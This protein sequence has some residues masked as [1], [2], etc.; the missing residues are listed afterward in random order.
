MPRIKVDV[1]E[2]PIFQTIIPVRI[3]DLNYGN[4]LGNDSLLSIIH[5]ARVQFLYSLGYS[6][7]NF[8]GV[9][10]IMADVAIEYKSQGYY[11]DQLKVSIGVKDISRVGFDITYSITKSENGREIIVAK[12]KTG[13]VTF[14]YSLNKVIELPATFLE[15]LP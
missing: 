4:H 8:A 3:T 6:E 10:L 9:G 5:E 12:A 14:D 1:A 13:M 2:N 15:K 7:Q 11:A